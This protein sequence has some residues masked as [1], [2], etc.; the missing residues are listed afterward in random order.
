LA[1]IKSNPQGLYCVGVVIKGDVGIVRFLVDQGQQ[2]V[3]QSPPPSLLELGQRTHWLWIV[4]AIRF[5]IFLYM[6]KGE[7]R[8]KSLPRF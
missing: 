4:H 2:A 1:V 3:E 6:N 5:L 7:R 8:L